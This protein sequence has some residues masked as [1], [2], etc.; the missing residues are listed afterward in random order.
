[1]KNNRI[2]YI[3]IDNSTSSEEDF[4]I[5]DADDEEKIDQPT[6]NTDTEFVAN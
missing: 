4:T 2:K 6:N 3:K 1:M 5:R